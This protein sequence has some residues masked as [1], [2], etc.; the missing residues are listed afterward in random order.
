MLT[1]ISIAIFVRLKGEKVI[2]KQSNIEITTS[3]MHHTEADKQHQFRLGYALHT[4][5]LGWIII[6]L[7][8]H[9][10]VIDW[11]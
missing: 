10:D 4:V 8:I 7:Y 6:F 5:D 1:K 2:K 11:D 9:K 3:T